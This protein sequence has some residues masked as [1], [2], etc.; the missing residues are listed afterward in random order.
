MAPSNTF[1]RRWRAPPGVKRKNWPRNKAGWKKK[2]PKKVRVSKMIASVAEMRRRESGLSTVSY[3]NQGPQED[4]SYYGLA[5]T[6]AINVVVD[7]LNYGWQNSTTD[8][9]GAVRQFRGKDIF[10]R[11]WKMKYKFDFPQGVDS[12]RH[13][14][15]LQLI[16]GFCTNPTQYTP[17]T[18]PTETAVTAA[19]YKAA[20]LAQVED[21]WNSPDDQLQFR[22]KNK[23]NIKVLGKQWIRPD[24]THR[25]GLPQFARGDG[26]DSEGGP[27]DVTGTLSW[28]VQR[29]MR[30]QATNN[31][32]D[33][34]MNYN[35]ES[36][37][38]F[39]IIYSP[40]FDSVYN[41]DDTEPREVPEDRR[42]QFQH[43]SCLWYQDP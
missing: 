15:R 26:T 28:P 41:P 23:S 17:Y 35:N 22:I 30:L 6:Q 27:P 20:I 39:V 32:D 11:Y 9:G 25:I 10:V 43:N 16:H 37:V 8:P 31:G 38:P 40:D 29:K 7:P 19:E 24:R 13:P 33:D 42:I 21:S 18:S 34:A 3:A 5:T 4:Q 1:H 36:W 14:M 2:Q 12:I